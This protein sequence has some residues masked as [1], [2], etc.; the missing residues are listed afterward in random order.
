MEPR[1]PSPSGMQGEVKSDCTT[2]WFLGK[3]EKVR[4][5]PTAATTF[6]GEKRRAA[7]APT[8]MSWLVVAEARVERRVV[9]RRVLE[10]MVDLLGRRKWLVVVIMF[11]DDY[12]GM[13]VLVVDVRLCVRVRVWIHE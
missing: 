10:S 9:V 11:G 3:K 13:C 5:S 2:E 4:V 12:V 7:E 6:S 1:G 8:V